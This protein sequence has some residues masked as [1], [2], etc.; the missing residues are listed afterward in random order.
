MEMTRPASF[1][2]E[3][4]AAVRDGEG[5]AQLRDPE[6]NRVFVVIEQP[7]PPTIGDEY[8]REKLDEAINASECGDVAEWDV[9]ALKAELRQRLAKKNSEQ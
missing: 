8:V 5:Y 1:T 9:D 3:Q 4:L 6:T 7:E 2:P